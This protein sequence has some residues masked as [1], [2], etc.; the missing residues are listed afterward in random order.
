MRPLRIWVCTLLMALVIVSGGTSAIARPITFDDLYSVPRASDPQVSPDC[1]HI[2]YVLRLTNTETNTQSSH[3]WLMNNDGSDPHQ[4]TFGPTN[5]WQPQW[6]ADGTGL[7]FLTDRSESAQVWFLPITGGEAR[8]MSH[9]PSLVS[10]FLVSPS[11]TT[12]ILTSKSLPHC[13]DDGCNKAEL[14]KAKNSPVQ[15]KLYDHLLYRHYNQWDDGCVSRLYVC[16]I[17][18]ETH[19]P[20]FMNETDVPTST[21]GGGEDVA[22]SRDG[23]TV[24]FTMQTDSVPAVRVNNDLFTV[25]ALAPEPL[26]LTSAPGLEN[27]PRYSPDGKYLSY[28]SMATPGYESDERDLTLMDRKSGAWSILTT[29]VDNSVGEY[30]WDSQS[31]H[32]YFTVIERGMTVVYR[33]NVES[34]HVERLLDGAVY[35]SLRLASDGS[36][37]VV[38]RSLSDQPHELYKYDLKSRALHRLTRVAEPT[39]KDID[40]TND[41][42]FWFIGANGDSVQGFLT[43]PPS[44]DGSRKYPLVLLIHGGPQWCW[45]RDFNYYGW[46]TQ[47]MAAQGYVVAQINPH[48][49][50]GYGRA[51]KEYVSGNWGKG[52]YDDLMMGVDYLLTTRS[53]IDSTRMAALGRSYGGFMTNW[54]C[55]HTDRFKCLVTIDGTANQIS[56]YGSTEE[57]WFPE[58]E[59]RGT[60]WS[61]LEEYMRSSP[62]M[63][64]DNFKTPTMVIH[65]Q[66]DYRVDLSEGLQ[67]FTALQRHGVPSQLLYFPDEGHHVGKL[68]N[69]RYVYEKQFEW[70]ARW[71]K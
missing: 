58:W 54:I 14:T 15:A 19:R 25:T 40:L 39:L 37:F 29:S 9:L 69:L 17:A 6:N 65:G 63:Y 3:L 11:G 48:G 10:D 28:L 32:I 1:R 33:V 45:L 5:E 62:I 4:L 66:R 31:R 44:F 26:Q 8:Q 2:A 70:L 13:A 24:C 56:D 61:N 7:F 53:F 18:T 22:V 67:M 71:L 49:S 41:E 68:V 27:S 43:R 34:R 38:S 46:N 47:L 16:D 30:V 35:N 20:L 51:F 64:A 50:V 42:D 36:F 59:S 55:G 60:P 21:L 12:L 57:L 52:D 23:L